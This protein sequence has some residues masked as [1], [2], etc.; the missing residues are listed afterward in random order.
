MTERFYDASHSSPAAEA[1]PKQVRDPRY[2][3]SAGSLRV[4]SV[5]V[6]QQKDDSLTISVMRPHSAFGI[7]GSGSGPSVVKAVCGPGTASAWAG[8]LPKSAVNLPGSAEYCAMVCL[9][10]VVVRIR[11]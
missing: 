4:R 6:I 10:R 7:G 8:D 2:Q 5:R 11:R 1:D 9:L 3:A